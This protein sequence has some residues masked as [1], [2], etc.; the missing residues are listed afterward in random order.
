M[1][2]RASA[3]SA[4]A[5]STSWAGGVVPWGV[6]E[7]EPRTGARVRH[8]GRV[9]RRGDVDGRSLHRPRAASTTEDGVELGVVVLGEEDLV[10]RRPGG[11]LVESQ[12][13][14]EA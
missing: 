8:E 11:D 12:Q 2:A 10:V 1:I 4:A 9:V 7:D 13:Q 14:D 6:D 3:S 5:R